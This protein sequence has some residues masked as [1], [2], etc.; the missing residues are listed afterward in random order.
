M[1]ALFD[2]EAFFVLLYGFFMICI[3]WV[4]QPLHHVEA[5]TSKTNNTILNHLLYPCIF[6]KSNLHFANIFLEVS[7][8]SFENKNIET[9]THLYASRV[10]KKNSLNF[11]WF[12]GF[13]E[14]T[15]PCS[16]TNKRTFILAQ[17]MLSPFPWKYDALPK[18]P[19]APTTI[20]AKRFHAKP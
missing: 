5:S 15:P 8:S 10:H 2:I 3:M 6:P 17:G 19:D 14:P 12:W 11:I 16:Y 1:H 18:T 20:R 7:F 13:Q 9:H 4:L